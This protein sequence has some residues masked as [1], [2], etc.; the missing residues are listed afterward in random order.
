M[1]QRQVRNDVVS[2]LYSGESL[3]LSASLIRYGTDEGQAGSSSAS[4]ALRGV[5]QEA[6]VWGLRTTSTGTEISCNLSMAQNRFR[7]D[8][9]GKYILA[10]RWGEWN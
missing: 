5:Q 9:T 2:L 6:F 7:Y 3:L 10:H 1:G 8:P 4:L